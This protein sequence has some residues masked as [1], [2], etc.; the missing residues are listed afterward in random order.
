MEPTEIAR[1]AV[2]LPPFWPEQPDVWFAQ[3]EAQFSLAGITNE[4]TKFHHII[5]QLDHRYAAEVRDI[6]TSPPQQ[7]PYTQLRTELLNRLSPSGEQRLRQLLTPEAMG[8][9]KPSQYLRHLRSL[10]PNASDDLL[11]TVWTSQLP[12]DIQIALAAQP[13]VQLD[14]AALCADRITEAVSRPALA[15]IGTLTNAELATQM[16]ELSGRMGAL[17]TEWNR[18]SSPRDRS[19]S[20]RD[21]PSSP[22][23]RPSSP[24]DRPSSW[25]DSPSH[26]RDRHYSTWDRRSS[27]RDRRSSPGSRRS[28]TRSPSRHGTSTTPCWYHRRFGDRAQNCSP[29]CTYSQQ[30]N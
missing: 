4:R 3:A 27:S 18:R 24:R 11:R 17:N 12:R 9:R 29:P 8:D 15:S 20:P 28:F 10:A 26:T 19:S 14:A 30:G 23:D 13:V 21:R 6:I 7:D 5:A 2:R 1:V 16:K 22:R 25:R